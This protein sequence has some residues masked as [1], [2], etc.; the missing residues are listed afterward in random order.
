VRVVHPD[1]AHQGGGV[2][3][4]I[5]QNRQR[6]LMGAT[7][8]LYLGPLLAGLAGQ[9]W[10][11]VP[12]FVAIFVLWLVVMRPWAW[13]REPRAWGN[14]QV[15]VGAASQVAVQTLLVVMCFAIGRGLGGVV[16]V[17]ALFHPLLPV[18][19][20]FL[21][22]PVSRLVWDPVKGREVDAFVDDAMAQLSS[23]ARAAAGPPDPAVEQLLDLAQGAGS[24]AVA[25]QIAQVLH[26]DKAAGRL[27]QLVTALDRQAPPRPVLRREVIL[28]ATD[29]A[30]VVAGGPHG[31]VARAFQVAGQ[32]PALLR[33]FADR[34]LPL[35]AARPDL[36]TQFP[37]P[38]DLVRSMDPALPDDLAAALEAMADAISHAMAAGGGA[39]GA[40]V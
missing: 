10:A 17:L 39:S 14:A 1:L 23:G 8:L 24:A 4:A 37:D 38:A 19:I 28:W 29:A 12:V 33:L 5:V 18:A 35:I 2:R 22:L 21:S 20:S 7:A 3:E 13:P 9:G 40:A 27:D 15:W 11:S 6:M 34:A 16:G 32:D 31:A 30:R 25:A 36:W 26:G